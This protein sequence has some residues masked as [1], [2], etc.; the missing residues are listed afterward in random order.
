MSRRACFRRLMPQSSQVNL[1]EDSDWRR[2]PAF[3]GVTLQSDGGSV[4]PRQG[5]ARLPI[6]DPPGR[7]RRARVA[8]AIRI[9]L[10]PCSRRTTGRC[11]DADE[12]F[13]GSKH[14]QLVVVVDDRA[15]ENPL[16]SIAQDASS[17]SQSS[18]A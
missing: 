12:V 5:V 3:V 6:C 1:K 9:L 10:D 13:H 17:E 16:R 7:R 4:E 8:A 14:R 15:T 18:I 11:A 2:S